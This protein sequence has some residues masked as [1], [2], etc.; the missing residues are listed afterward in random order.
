M[1][2]ISVYEQG[3]KQLV[4]SALKKGFLTARFSRHELRINREQRAGEIDLSLD[5][6]P[7]FL[8]G[9]TT[10]DQEIIKPELLARYLPYEVGD[11]WSP[12]KI[13][14]LQKVLYAPIFSAGYRSGAISSRPG[15]CRSRYKSNS[16][17]RSI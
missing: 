10:S 8:F 14:E 3:K 13:S 9:I 6:G 7:R 15:T 17:P 11:P 5:T 4:R 12:A 1:F 2:S 16:R